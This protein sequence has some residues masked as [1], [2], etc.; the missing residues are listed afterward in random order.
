[1]TVMAVET[2]FVSGGTFVNV[3]RHDED[4]DIVGVRSNCVPGCFVFCGLYLSGLMVVSIVACFWL[5]LLSVCPKLRE[6]EGS[7]AGRRRM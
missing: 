3:E 7:G 6:S 2:D 4:C 1:M 5:F